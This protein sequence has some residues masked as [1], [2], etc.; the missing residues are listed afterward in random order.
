VF[1]LRFSATSAAKRF[2]AAENAERRRISLKEENQALRV[3]Y[4][5]CLFLRFS[6]T[7]AAKRFFAAENAERRGNELGGETM[8]MLR[9]AYS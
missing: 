5:L 6:A 3:L 8:E 1:F 7:S 9:E 4:W 2:L